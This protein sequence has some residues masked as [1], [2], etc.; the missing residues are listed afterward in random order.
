MLRILL[1]EDNKVIANNIKKYI[2]LDWHSVMIVENGIYAM[3]VGK[4][5]AFDVIIL[6]IMLPGVDG[7]TVCKTIR[8][9]HPETPIIMTTAKGQLEDKLEWFS[10]WADDYIVKPFDIEELMARIIAL[11]KRTNKKNILEY[12]NILL[13]KDQRKIYKNTKEVKCTMKEYLILE[14]LL[15]NIWKAISRTDIIEEIWGNEKIYEED[16]KLDVYISKLRKKFWK[17]SIETV[18]GYGYK[19]R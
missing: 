2:E 4:H 15:S 13:N 5:Q 7:N 19:L 8:K 16:A 11:L 10:S 6:D 9:T 14:L 18:H 17:T 3:E 1:V 12:K